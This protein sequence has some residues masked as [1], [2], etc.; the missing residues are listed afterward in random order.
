MQIFSNE[1]HDRFR[2]KPISTILYVILLIAAAALIGEFV[3]GFMD[4]MA[5]G[6]SDGI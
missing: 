6:L 2:R 4:G 3:T 5:A 1:L